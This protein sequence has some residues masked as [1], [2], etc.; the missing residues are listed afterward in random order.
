MFDSLITGKNECMFECFASPFNAYNSRYCSIFHQDLDYHFGSSGDFFSVPLGYFK[1]HGGELHEANPPFA[2]GLMSEMVGRLIQH[3]EFADYESSQNI[4]DGKLTFVVVVPTCSNSDA[5]L[6][7]ESA[8]DSFKKMIKSPYFCK[9]IILKAREHGYVEGSQHLRQ[10][11]YKES[12]YSTSVI[13]LQS[14]KS[15]EFEKSAPCF[16][17]E[18]LETKIRKSFGSR[19][20]DELEERRLHSNFNTSIEMK[21]NKKKSLKRVKKLKK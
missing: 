13:F 1:K 19:H 20:K 15:R 12:Q 18:E 4:N 16:K 3:L 7:Q 11:R 6:V 9:H 8:N 2:P 10:T 14:Q 17:T 5:N 21:D